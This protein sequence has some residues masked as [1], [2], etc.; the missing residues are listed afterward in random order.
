MES[1]ARSCQDMAKFSLRFFQDW[2]FV[3]VKIPILGKTGVEN[4]L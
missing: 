3:P 2:K 1:L 4:F